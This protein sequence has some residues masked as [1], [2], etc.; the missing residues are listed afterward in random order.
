[1]FQFGYQDDRLAA[2][3]PQK[4]LPWPLGTA[5]WR[6]WR[7][8]SP[9][10]LAPLSGRANFASF[11]GTRATS[12]EK[13]VRVSGVV[14]EFTDAQAVSAADVYKEAD[15]DRYRELL[16]TSQ[17]ALSPPERSANT[18]RI[19]EAVE[20]G[21]V[22]VIVPGTNGRNTTF[23]HNNWSGLYGLPVGDTTAYPWIPTAPF[24]TL[25]S[26]S[27]LVG[28]AQG[29][30]VGATDETG[31][32]LQSWYRHWRR[33]FHDQLEQRVTSS[34]AVSATTRE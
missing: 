20:S 5:G 28:D 1:V 2:K 33:A 12:L 17:Y 24:R 31:A 9:K 11:R 13:L 15:A 8:P 30:R 26:F 7:T 25:H 19:Q 18:Y 4:Y 6:N 21:A 16:A 22:P 3:D 32:K 29:M 14:V 27:D 23:C 10:S 34:L